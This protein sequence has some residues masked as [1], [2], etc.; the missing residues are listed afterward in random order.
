[1]SHKYLENIVIKELLKFLEVEP[2]HE[3]DGDHILFNVVDCSI[4]MK[5]SLLYVCIDH[6]L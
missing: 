3:I 6:L 1:M 4:Y 2:S 5:H